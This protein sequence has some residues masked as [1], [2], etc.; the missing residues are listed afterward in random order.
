M[1]G[2]FYRPPSLVKL[3]A[4]LDTNGIPHTFEAKVISPLPSLHLAKDLVFSF[5]FGLIKMVMIG[6]R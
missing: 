2:G 5:Q 4:E 1:R 6:P 3:K